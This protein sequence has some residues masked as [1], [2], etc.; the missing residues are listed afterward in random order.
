MKS[1]ED[2]I[3]DFFTELKA[4]DEQLTP[5]PF[6]GLPQRKAKGRVRILFPLLAAASVL[7][8]LAFWR[9]TPVAIPSEDQAQILVISLEPKKETQTESLIADPEPLFSWESP[10]ASLIADF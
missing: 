6:P 3:K 7:L 1:S 5:P 8:L 9:T 4:K 2:D 10:S